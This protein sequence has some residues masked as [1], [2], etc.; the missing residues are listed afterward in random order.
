MINV[1]VSDYDGV[2]II[3][4]KHLRGG[5]ERLDLTSV[6]SWFCTAINKNLGLIGSNQMHSSSNL[7]V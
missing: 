5:K 4:G 7:S 1:S 3:Q 6:T 2:D